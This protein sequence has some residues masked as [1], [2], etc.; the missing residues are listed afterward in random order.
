MV[1]ATDAR[2]VVARPVAVAAAVARARLKEIAGR[3]AV[4]TGLAGAAVV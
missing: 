2:R 3:V 4:P 1:T